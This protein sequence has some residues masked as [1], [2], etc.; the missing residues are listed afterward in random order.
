MNFAGKLGFILFTIFCSFPGVSVAQGT[1]SAKAISRT[2]GRV[3]SLF[4]LSLYYG[5]T[6]ATANPAAGN[7]WQNTTAIYDFKAGYI[8]DDGLYFGADYSSRSDNQISTATVSGSSV[9]IGTGYFGESGFNL[10]AFYKFN[11]SYGDYKDGTGF[12]ADV[13]YLLNPTSNFFF[14]ISVAVRQTTYKTNATIVGFDSW[15]RKET[16]PFFTLGF[17][18][19]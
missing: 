18:I 14:G 11:D 6:E 7:S 5:Q 9:G 2:Y 13:G 8:T 10:R 17:L 16:Y 1:K 19:N 3:G 12:Q 4:D 15:S